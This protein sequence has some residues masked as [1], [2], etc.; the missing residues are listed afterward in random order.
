MVGTPSRHI[1]TGFPYGSGAGGSV[2]EDRAEFK[3]CG[4]RWQ[5]AH[6]WEICPA[7]FLLGD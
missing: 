6:T 7:S 2:T 3:V 5:S 4:L 1:V